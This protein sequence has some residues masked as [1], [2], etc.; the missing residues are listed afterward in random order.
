MS[1]TLAKPS[2]QK[3]RR[4]PATPNYIYLMP[5][6][7]ILEEKMFEM[8]ID[9]AELAR[10]MEVPVETIEQLLRYEIPLTKEVAE[11]IETATWMSANAMMRHESSYRAKLAYAVEHPEIP[12]YLGDKIVNQPKK[13]KA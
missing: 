7:E 6:G 11:K 12:A 5:P 3:K 13:E 1:T 9:A 8:G 4:A 10:R 2:Q